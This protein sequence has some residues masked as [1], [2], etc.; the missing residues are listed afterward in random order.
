MPI[1]EYHCPDCGARKE[2][3]QKLA[4]AVLSTCPACSGTQYQKQLSA[5]AFQLKGSGWYVTDFRGGDKSTD[6]PA[7]SATPATA[8]P[9]PV[10]AATGGGE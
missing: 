7:A 6:K 3:L 5:A 8:A 9:A 4:D 1:Y 2:H 10:A